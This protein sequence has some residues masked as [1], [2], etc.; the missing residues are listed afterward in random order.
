MFPHPSIHKC[1]WTTADGKTHNQIYP[2]LMDRRWY[3]GILGVRYFRG[4]DFG[5]DHYVMVAKVREILA[6]SKL[7]TQTFDLEDLISGS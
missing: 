5:T 7:A 4:A 6:V 2:I 3:S 1:T